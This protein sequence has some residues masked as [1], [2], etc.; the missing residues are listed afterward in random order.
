MIDLA[1]TLA[2]RRAALRPT[3]PGRRVVVQIVAPAVF[4]LIV[5]GA[6]QLYADLSGVRESTL[7]KPTEVAATLYTDA[8]LL[9][10]SSLVTLKEILIGYALS[11]VLG[12][13]LAALISSSRTIER[14]V[15]P[16]LVASQMVPVPAIAPVLV[17]WLGFDI[18]PKVIVIALVAFF[19]I[20]VNTIDGLKAADPELIALLK[21]L[22]ASRPQRFRLAQ[23]P[24]ALPFVFSGLKVAAAFSVIGAVFGE[25]VGSSSGLG[26]LILTFNNQTAT[27]DMFAVIVVLAVIGI[28]L[29]LC[30][31]L[32]E[33]LALPW[34]YEARSERHD[35][36]AE[37]AEEP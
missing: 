10:T 27:A 6:W 8:G 22:G 4:A 23:A 15:Y 32:V 24:A 17:L 26:Y 35:V 16:W 2:R 13:G 30:V 12:V 5:L 29:F 20:V 7:P 31:G 21:T 14:A 1:G 25:W 34:Y 18:R 37:E 3:L 33:R 28:C 36:E 11:I 9:W 19:P